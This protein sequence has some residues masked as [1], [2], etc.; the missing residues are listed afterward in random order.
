LPFT[1]LQPCNFGSNAV[2]SASLS[3]FAGMT[4]PSVPFELSEPLCGATP[5]SA[6]FRLLVVVLGKPRR[7]GAGLA[8]PTGEWANFPIALHSPQSM[9]SANNCN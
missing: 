4:V 2:I 6:T 5:P 3:F 1:T 9:Q 7:L 8:G